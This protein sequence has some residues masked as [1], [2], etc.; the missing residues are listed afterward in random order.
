MI[1]TSTSGKFWILPKGHPEDALNKLQVAVLETYEEA[2]IKGI[3]FERKLG[4]EFNRKEGGSLIIYPLLIKK[5][6]DDSIWPEESRR[7]RRL[8]SIKKALSLVTKQEHRQAIKYFSSESVS[9]KLLK[10][11]ASLTNRK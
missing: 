10:I 3:I 4:K 11:I 9:S 7:K 5:I 6:L 8:V 1:V 2:G